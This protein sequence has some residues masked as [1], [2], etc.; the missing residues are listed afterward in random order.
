M[1]LGNPK[2]LVFFL[3]L[4]PSVVDLGALTPIG[5]AELAAIVALIVTVVFGGYALAAARARRLFSSPRAVRLLNRGS[6]MAL[7]GAAAAVAAR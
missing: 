6:A 3:A 4:L 5:F 7:A 1:N 2:A